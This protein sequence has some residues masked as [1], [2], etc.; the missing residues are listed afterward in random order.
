MVPCFRY[1][2]LLLLLGQ[3]PVSPAQADDFEEARQLI[4]ENKLEQAYQNL[5]TKEAYHIG[6]VEYDLLLA[7]TALKTGHP[8][9]AIF[10]YER[11]LINQPGHHLARVE[12][13][14]AHYQINELENSRQLF[15]SA[16]KANP[17]DNIRQTILKYI[18]RIN[19][20]IE[21]RKHSLTGILA[22]KLGRDSNINSA[23]NATEVELTIGTYR[24][25][26]GVDKETADSYTELSNHL[27][28]KYNF[29]INSKFFTSLGYANRDNN[30]KEFDTEIADVK[31]GY[32]HLTGIGRLSIP[33][34]YQT[35]WLDEKQLREVTVIVPSLNRSDEDSYTDY[36]L[37]YG[38]IRYPDQPALDVDFVA[39]SFAFGFA[40]KSS[41]FSQQYALFYGDETALN[42]LYDFNARKYWGVQIR[43]PLRLTQRH[44]ITP[45]V[46]YQEAVYQQQHP[47]FTAKRADDYTSYLL[48]W[49]WYISR[50]WSLTAQASYADS[51]SSVSLYT[52]TRTIFFTG[53]SFNY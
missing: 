19:E 1:I 18:D 36:S 52:H 24:P 17:P 33:V 27:H 25:T 47:F 32:S 14:I 28:Y 29:N 10:A 12:L 13:A 30:N 9:E 21:S 41:G 45:K 39:A 4:K 22:L 16:L 42:S 43:L 5:T 37:Q 2:P 34:S 6:E 53:I 15:D 23:T 40:D 50:R 3:Y 11:V 38:E 46:V 7:R 49:Q 26:D 35:M 51:S 48:D 8:H 44:M 20:K 31:A